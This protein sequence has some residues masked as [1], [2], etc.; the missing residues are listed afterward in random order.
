[1]ITKKIWI[2]RKSNTTE[3][4]ATFLFG[5]DCNVEVVLPEP[6]EIESMDGKKWK[7]TASTPHI[8]IETTCEKQESML[9]L[10][11]G[12]EL[13]LT[14]VCHDILPTRTYFPG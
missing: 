13:V 11:Y 4:D 9:K 6:F 10:K 14:Q 2:L 1:M 8:K 3:I 5:L 7:Y 12:D